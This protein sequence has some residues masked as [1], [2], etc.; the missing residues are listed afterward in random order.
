MLELAKTSWN[1]AVSRDTSSLP[2]ITQHDLESMARDSLIHAR[3]VL[4]I[5]GP[6]G[7]EDGPMEE[8]RVMRELLH[9]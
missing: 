9:C 5:F 7:D 4:E 8:I 6:E 1:Y 3:A 2:S